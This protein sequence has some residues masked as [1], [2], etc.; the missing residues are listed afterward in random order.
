[1]IASNLKNTFN[2]NDLKK[3]IKRLTLNGQTKDA[4]TKSKDGSWKYDIVEAGL[5][6]NLPD[7]NAAIALGQLKSKEK[8]IKTP[9]VILNLHPQSF[10]VYL[11]CLKIFYIVLLIS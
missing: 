5:K 10:W 11:F 4:Y 8:I 9:N 6:C 2:L 3:K 1:M 7:I